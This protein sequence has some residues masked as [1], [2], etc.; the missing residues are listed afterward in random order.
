[1]MFFLFNIRGLVSLLP[2]FIVVSYFTY[3]HKQTRRE[4]LS[5][6]VALTR[7][8]SYLAI[9]PAVLLSGYLLDTLNNHWVYL[10]PEIVML[11]PTCD[12]MHKNHDV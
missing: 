11:L 6:V 10:I 5:R 9:T 8:I 7:L 4:L 3:R 1:M 2:M 12:F